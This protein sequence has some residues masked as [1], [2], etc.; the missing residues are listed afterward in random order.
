[1]VWPMLQ[2]LAGR[3]HEVS[4]QLTHQH[5]EYTTPYVYQGV[6]VVPLGAPDALWR[7]CTGTAPPDLMITHMD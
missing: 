2:A 3:G 7:W 4:V 6:Q 5:R 1:M